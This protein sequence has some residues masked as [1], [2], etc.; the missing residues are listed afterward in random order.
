MPQRVEK[1]PPC[2]FVWER[3]E[4]SMNLGA[5]SDKIQKIMHENFCFLLLSLGEL[6]GLFI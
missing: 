6:I 2:D 1:Y 3:N 5:I 4:L